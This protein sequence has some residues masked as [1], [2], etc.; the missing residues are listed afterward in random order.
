M[1]KSSIFAPIFIDRMWLTDIGFNLDVE[2]AD[3]MTVKVDINY[4]VSGLTRDEDGVCRE[5]IDLT[6]RA[7]L[8]NEEDDDDIRLSAMARIQTFVGADLPGISDDKAE[9]Y[10]AKN[11]LSMS[12]AHARSCIMSVTALSPM[13]G[14]ILPPVIPDE[15]INEASQGEP[16]S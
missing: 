7:F 5:S 11:A 16:S 6:V 10:L 14:F 13:R 12:Y 15:I 8:V 9:R 3:S 2:P 1:S 4:E